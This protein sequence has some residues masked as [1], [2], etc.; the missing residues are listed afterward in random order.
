MRSRVCSRADEVLRDEF[1]LAGWVQKVSKRREFY[2]SWCDHAARD[3]RQ[4]TNG[5]E[6]AKESLVLT[7][8]GALGE[9]ESFAGY[10]R[11]RGGS[12]LTEDGNWDKLY[13]AAAATILEEYLDAV[14]KGRWP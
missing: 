8:V 11:R 5:G 3:L 4:L 1:R 9:D 10:I 12:F 6:P 13:R 14:D 7:L 2:F